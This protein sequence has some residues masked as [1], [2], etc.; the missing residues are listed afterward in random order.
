MSEVRTLE[1]TLPTFAIRWGG[2]VVSSELR[3][4]ESWKLESWKSHQASRSADTQAARQVTSV[5]AFDATK[6]QKL[7]TA[8]FGSSTRAVF[9][10]FGINCTGNGKHHAQI[11]L[12]SKCIHVALSQGDGS[13]G[14]RPTCQVVR[15]EASLSETCAILENPHKNQNCSF[16]ELLHCIKYQIECRPYLRKLDKSAVLLL[17]LQT[18]NPTTLTSARL[19]E[20]CG[21]NMSKSC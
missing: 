11:C 20:H 2:G 10:I 12:T 3:K 13:K 4:S 7:L 17:N 16:V 6:N 5:D 21:R 18:K 14:I 1:A 9:S 19:Q 15:M 8:L